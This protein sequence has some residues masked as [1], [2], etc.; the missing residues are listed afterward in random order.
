MS[1]T[2]TFCRS[3][4]HA[5]TFG[6]FIF[7]LVS[8]S[9]F[10]LNAY[11]QTAEAPAISAPVLVNLPTPEKAL[12]P[13]TALAKPITLVL[14]TDE[15]V[16]QE[17]SMKEE[18]KQAAKMKKEKMA[19]A[20]KPKTDE[21]QAPVRLHSPVMAKVNANFNKEVPRF[22]VYEGEIPKEEKTFDINPDDLTLSIALRRWGKQ[23]GYQIV[24]DAAKDLVAVS[25]SYKGPLESAITSLMED[26]NFSDYPLHAC[27]YQNKVIRVLHVSQTCVRQ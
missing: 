17:N 26:T 13:K 20:Q 6:L 19:A 15:A 8:G 16:A 25:T 24:W 5:P 12:K 23:S 27:S 22:S 9:T 2:I 3:R 10:S 1:R 7:A 21:E 4:F 14:P 18:E 11:S